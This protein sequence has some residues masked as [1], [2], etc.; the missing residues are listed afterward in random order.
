[1]PSHGA[2]TVIATVLVVT[3]AALLV[4]AF[5]PDSSPPHVSADPPAHAFELANEVPPEIEGKPLPDA[6]FEAPEDPVV[7]YPPANVTRTLNGV[8]FSGYYYADCTDKYVLYL[9][10]RPA[11]RMR[12]IAT[13]RNTDAA[14]EKQTREI[15]TMA[16][17]LHESRV[18]DACTRSPTCHSVHCVGFFCSLQN[19]GCVV[20]SVRNN[21]PATPTLWIAQRRTPNKKHLFKRARADIA[22]WNKE[23]TDKGIA[24]APPVDRVRSAHNFNPGG[25]YRNEWSRCSPAA[26]QRDCR[27]TLLKEAERALQKPLAPE[28]TTPTISVTE[29]DLLAFEHYVLVDPVNKFIFFFIPKVASTEFLKLYDRLVGHTDY[30][31]LLMV[32]A[33]HFRFDDRQRERL[34]LSTFSCKEAAQ[35]LNS[36][37]YKKVVFFR[38][39]CVRALS[40]YL[41]KFVT[42]NSYAVKVFG[43]ASKDMSFGDYLA[44]VADPVFFS[45][46]GPHMNGTGP[47]VN[48]H[49]RNQVMVANVYKFFP[50][51]DFVGW[52]DGAHA[53]AFLERYGLWEQYGRAGWSNQADG[54]MQRAK[55]ADRHATSSKDKAASYYKP[56]LRELTEEA[57]AMD[58]QLFAE[59]GLRR[60]GP[61]VDG[62]RFPRRADQCTLDRCW[63]GA[64]LGEISS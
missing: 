25:Q 44:H 27:A 47:F 36:L 55:T 33:P 41:D 6:E 29:A 24:L 60:D 57:Y 53:K 48:A 8:S 19:A 17:T 30:D 32:S 43:K 34:K 9:S 11:N 40:A 5:I 20:Q 13:V 4:T 37:A 16:Q 7:V 26:S 38:D 39:P 54:F 62:S 14:K 35:L 58:Y 10:L 18:L 2:R 61:P 49:W 46:S 56:A 59:L 23:Y 21:T 31:S 42:Q 15:V 63:P 28:Y 52:G 50:L 22:A 64:A 51:M 3:T 12:L 45:P 1:M